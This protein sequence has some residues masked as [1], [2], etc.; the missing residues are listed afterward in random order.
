MKNKGINAHVGLAALLVACLD[1]TGCAAPAAKQEFQ[2]SD[3]PVSLES[4]SETPA[5]SSQDD[6]VI[7]RT[8]AEPV[9]PESAPTDAQ[10]GN[11]PESWTNAS[12]SLPSDSQV[13]TQPESESS[14]NLWQR[15]RAGF[16]LPDRDHPGVE[17]DRQ[18]FLGH[19][20]YIQRTLERARPY[21]F[22][23]VEEVQIRGMPM[24]IALLPIVESAFQP[25]AYSH[26]RAAGIWQF[27]PGTGRLY[28]LKQNWW[29]DGRRDVYASTQSAL[30]LLQDLQKQFNGDWLLALAAYNSGAGTVSRAIKKNQQLGKPTD[31]WSL[32]LPKETRGYVPKLLAITDVV[33]KADEYGISLLDI[34]NE[35]YFAVVDVASQIDLGVAA[36]LAGIETD[37][38]YRLNPGFNRWATDPEGPHHLLVPLASAQG[39]SE[40]L[41]QLPED[42][43]VKW[44]RHKVESGETL[45]TIA[46]KY[47]TSTALVAEVND[48]RSHAL[49][50]GNYL[51]IPAAKKELAN[52]SLTADRRLAS[53][54]NQ[55]REGHKTSYLVKAGDTFWSIARQFNVGVKQLASWNG[56]APRD[57]LK[58]NQRLVVWSK[59]RPMANLAA[60]GN[61]QKIRYVVRRGDSLAAIADKF[62][63]T[64]KDLARWNGLN[65]KK[66]LKPG[67]RLTL[68]IDVIKQS[69]N[70]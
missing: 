25:F 37:D 17:S 44:V 3:Q 63:V 47:H 20:D 70:G 59:N 51:L 10:A 45:N 50:A 54:Q 40:A 43:R 23:I 46:K 18:W 62:K 24:D 29:Y 58:A 68:F 36:E 48:L 32:D 19:Q 1:L 41:A 16:A 53:L 27:I 26:G 7:V 60:N 33:D 64:I 14:S 55:R 28:G 15:L 34:P 22:Y 4:T 69:G 11:E 38:M 49:R 12:D 6:A 5:A 31:Y 8:S 39:F 57:T 66:H 21:L 67:Q 30:N 13:A 35:P 9:A 42:Q 56:M 65:S 2:A 52:Y 61:T